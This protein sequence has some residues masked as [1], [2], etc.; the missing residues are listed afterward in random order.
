MTDLFVLPSYASHAIEHE[1]HVSALL[2]FQSIGTYARS[3]KS[4]QC[5]VCSELYF[6]SFFFYSSMAFVNS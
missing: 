6:V 3:R 2:L 5:A 1:S 4:Q